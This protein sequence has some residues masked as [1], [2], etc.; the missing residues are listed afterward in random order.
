ML[1]VNF[2]T[3][4]RA[5]SNVIVVLFLWRFE[6]TRQKVKIILAIEDVFFLDILGIILFSKIKGNSEVIQV[7]DLLQMGGKN[8]KI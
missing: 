3:K 5:I 1:G 6:V 4:N 2:R 7:G 8:Q